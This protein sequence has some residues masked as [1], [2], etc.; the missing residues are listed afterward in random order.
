MGSLTG[1]GDPAEAGLGE[2]GVGGVTRRSLLVG[3]GLGGAA[4]V[5]GPRLGLSDAW[6]DVDT[7]VPGGYNED[8]QALSV[9]TPLLPPTP[10]YAQ[11]VQKAWDGQATYARQ[12]IAWSVVYRTDADVVRGATSWASWD[13]MNAAFAAEAG[14]GQARCEVAGRSGIR[15][16]PVVHGCPPEF[17]EPAQ[18]GGPGWA[19]PETSTSEPSATSSPIRS[20]TSSTPT[21]T[22]QQS[23][24]AT[25][26]NL[27]ELFGAV[28][29]R[30]FAAMINASRDAIV[31]YKTRVDARGRRF[32]PDDI[33]IIT[34]GLSLV[35]PAD[36]RTTR[37]IPLGGSVNGRGNPASWETYSRTSNS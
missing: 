2:R 29:V 33:T 25:E 17:A 1:G 12:T 35:Q 15:L 16:L 34:G 5:L 24:F 14:A 31:D 27:F 21:E 9:P 6:A 20:R 37:T 19:Y 13:P 26:P 4:L 30:K 36:P 22:S 8:W 32:L 28:P 3:A 11:R 18:S 10:T 23:R 7:A